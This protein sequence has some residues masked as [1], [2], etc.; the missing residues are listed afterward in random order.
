MQDLGTLGG[1]ESWAYG[2]SADGSVVV[3]SAQNAAGGIVPFAGRR[4]VAWKT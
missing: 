3:G 2:V 1:N 4:R